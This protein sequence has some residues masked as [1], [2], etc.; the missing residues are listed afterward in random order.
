MR[1]VAD[2][3]GKFIHM[4]RFALLLISVLI[5]GVHVNLITSSTSVVRFTDRKLLLM[6]I[7]DV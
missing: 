6:K 1:S 3:R 2:K 4:K 5:E 7:W